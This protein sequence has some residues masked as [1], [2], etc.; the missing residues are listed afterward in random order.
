[1]LENTLNQSISCSTFTYE[2]Q[3]REAAAF[4][5]E[6]ISQCSALS[7]APSTAILCGSGL[8]QCGK[9]SKILL[10]ISYS[11]IPN[12]PRTTVQG[13]NGEVVVAMLQPNDVPCIFLMGRFH[14][15]EGFTWTQ[16]AFPIRTLALLGVQRLVVTTAAGALNPAFKVGDL[17]QMG[18]HLNL[19]GLCGQNPLIGLNM[20][21]FGKRFQEMTGAYSS[22]FC[23]SFHQ[24]YTSLGDKASIRVH[25]NGVHVTVSGPTYETRAE[26]RM[27]RLLGGDSVSMS[28]APSVIVAR[29]CGMQVLGFAFITNECAFEDVNCAPSHEEV[30]E[31][32]RNSGGQVIEMIIDFLTSLE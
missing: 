18:D 32:A 13:H 27:L 25:L 20:E 29:H 6:Q 8:Q 31:A 30:L 1:M 4:L 24:Y 3:L 15:Y 22:A 17:M 10:R 9:N 12:F 7:N 26:C 11:Q 28:G 2:C 21:C 5:N 16:V 14:F 23:T 19:P